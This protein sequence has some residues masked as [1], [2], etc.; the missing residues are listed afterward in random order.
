ME[1]EGVFLLRHSLKNS[2]LQNNEMEQ[3]KKQNNGNEE[4][5]RNAAQ[6]GS[7]KANQAERN[8][9]EPEL[10]KGIRKHGSDFYFPRKNLHA[11]KPYKDLGE[12]TSRGGNYSEDQCS[13]RVKNLNITRQIKPRVAFGNV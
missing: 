5:S 8:R 7:Q 6:R 9:I 11:E 12:R 1:Q 3:A 10:D 2:S 13:H 4:K